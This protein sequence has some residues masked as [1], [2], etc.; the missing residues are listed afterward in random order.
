MNR[1]VQARGLTRREKSM[2]RF[3]AQLPLH[4]MVWPVLIWMLIFSY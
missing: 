4:L 3:G 2:R 1:S